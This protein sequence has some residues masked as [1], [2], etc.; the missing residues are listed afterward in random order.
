MNDELKVEGA[1][2]ILAAL[3]ESYCDG[4][5][6]LGRVVQRFR[7]LAGLNANGVAGVFERIHC[8]GGLTVNNALVD[9]SAEPGPVSSRPEGRA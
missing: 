9:A 8:A 4:G 5:H 7:E 3:F 6:T 2:A 1:E